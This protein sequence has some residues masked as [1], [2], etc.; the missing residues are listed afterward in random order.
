MGI[1]FGGHPAGWMGKAAAVDDA[2]QK[3]APGGIAGS[4]PRS[5][6]SPGFPQMLVRPVSKRGAESGDGQKRRRGPKRSAIQP[7]A[8]IRIV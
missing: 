7:P 4:T 2:E 3:T 6:P 8:L 5:A 1:Q